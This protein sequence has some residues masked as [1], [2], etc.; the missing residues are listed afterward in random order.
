MNVFL[1]VGCGRG[2]SSSAK[3]TKRYSNAP[4]KKLSEAEKV[5]FITPTIYYIGDY[6]GVK[7]SQC[8]ETT[9]ISLR[10]EK[11]DIV[12][13]NLCNKAFNGCKMQGSCY[14]DIDGQKT[15]INYHKKLDDGKIQFMLVDRAHCKYGMG[16]SSDAKHSFSEM[17]LD[18]F[19]SVAADNSIYPLGTVIYIPTVAGTVLPDGST[20]D[21]YFIV[22]D[23]GGNID[24][25]GRFDFFTGDFGLNAS[26]PFLDLGLGGE[27]NFDYQV[28]SDSDAQAVRA[29]R[30]FPL[31][32]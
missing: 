16:D 29:H 10:R 27:S 18:P 7:S 11:S 23:S 4:K 31:L 1:L 12:K 21:G 2:D 17:C 25:N 22:R 32:K 19:Y 24:G 30:G 28:V 9:E 20:H 6:S 13:M 8:S 14:I 15:M 3:N 5:K 26:N